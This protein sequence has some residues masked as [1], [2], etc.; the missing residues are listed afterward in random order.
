MGIDDYGIHKLGLQESEVETSHSAAQ[1]VRTARVVG[2]SGRNEETLF[3]TQGYEVCTR[4]RRGVRGVDEG[5]SVLQVVRSPLF[6]TA[7]SYSAGNESYVA[8][9]AAALAAVRSHNVDLSLTLLIF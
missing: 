5:W 1:Q 6:E 4:I 9:S 3:V 8:W 7:A 2:G